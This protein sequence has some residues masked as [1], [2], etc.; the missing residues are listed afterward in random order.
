M[1]GYRF[2]WVLF[3]APLA[4]LLAGLIWLVHL[5]FESGQA[6]PQRSS[7]RADPLGSKALHDAYAEVSGLEVSRNF[8]P[9]VQLRELPSNA[10]LLLLNLRGGAF[11]QLADFDVIVDFVDRGGQ[12]VI[13]LNPDAV[14]Y[15]YLDDEDELR[16]PEAEVEDGSK[17]VNPGHTRRP[18]NKQESIWG[19]L[20]LRHGSHAGGKAV[21]II[22][23]GSA[24][25]L[26]VELPWREGGVLV[27]WDD[28]FWSP[29]YQI[30]D[31]VVAVERAYGSGRIVVMT[32]DYLFSNEA[33]LKH[34]FPALLSWIV[35]G[36]AALIFEETHLGVAEAAGVATLIR[37]Y[38]LS[39]FA[40]AFV[41]LMALVVWRGSSPLLPA[42]DGR[43]REAIIRA[44]HSV[45]AGLSELIQRNVPA[46]AMPEL[47]FRQWQQAFIR[48]DAERRKYAGE[49]EEIEAL[50]RA[51][52][53]LPARQR[54]PQ[55]T[56]LKIKSILNRNQRKR[57]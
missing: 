30:E 53:S 35:G 34:R 31:E 5:H 15:E 10:T 22:D 48:T 47:A 23:S 14:A 57:P 20:S 25:G 49:V 17:R 18:R 50:L 32:D 51:Q 2:S 45:E 3:V 39:G 44:E 41:G 38:R 28:E 42:F 36:R 21:R 1:S 40:V 7:L 26:P 8:V 29:L 19:G 33:L 11:H 46:A 12:L 13:A 9:F 37:R 55:E 56:H 16:N 24:G 43:G 4:G 52:A 6:Y 54:R 27:E